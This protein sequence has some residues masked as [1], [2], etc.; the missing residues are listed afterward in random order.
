MAVKVA[1]WPPL[2]DAVLGDKLRLTVKGNVAVRVTAAVAVLVGSATLDAVMVTVWRLEIV[3]GAVYSPFTMVPT[4]GLSDQVTAV[5]LVP[6]TEAAEGGRGCCAQRH[7]CWPNRHRDRR[8]GHRGA[9]GLGGIRRARCSYCDGLRA[10]DN[11]RRMINAIGDGADLWIQRPSH[12]CVGVSAQG[13]CER[14][15]LALPGW[16]PVLGDKLRFTVEGGVAI[17]VTMAVAVLVGSATLDAVMVTVCSAARRW[18]EQCTRRSTMVPTAGLSDHVTPVLLL[19]VTE[20][21]NVADAPAP[22]DTEAGPIVTAT[23]VRDTVALAVL[24]VSA[25]L[26]AVTVTVSCFA[27]IVGA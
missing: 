9:R 5:L 17:R 3:A 16:T 4:A 12:G 14:R 19:P 25:A 15:A 26:V 13:G 2:S 20:A 6:V 10:R 24:V 27:T 22:S 1:L 18:R 23:G 11:R 7:R 8:Q 21:L